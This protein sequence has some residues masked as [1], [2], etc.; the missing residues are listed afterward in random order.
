VTETDRPTA[1]EVGAF[2]DDLRR[3]AR[4]AAAEGDR[5]TAR[6]LRTLAEIHWPGENVR[7]K[8]DSLGIDW[9]ESNPDLGADQ[10][11]QATP[12]TPTAEVQQATPSTERAPQR[13]PQS[14]AQLRAE[15]LQRTVEAGHPVT[16]AYGMQGQGA[17]LVTAGADYDGT[18]R[19][20]DAHGRPSGGVVD[21]LDEQARAELAALPAYGRPGSE[22]NKKR[23]VEIRQAAARRAAQRA[24]TGPAEPAAAPISDS[25]AFIDEV[26]RRQ[27]SADPMQQITSHRQLADVA[28]R[29]GIDPATYGRR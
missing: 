20:F 5:I 17:K 10:P 25:R 13:G 18:S 21:G 2:N 23:A 6:D 8:S 7:V 1:D 19:V 15:A 28:H 4:E 24:L 29:H 12:V 22:K 11:E 16:V 9:L 14:S 27:A 26:E 3:V